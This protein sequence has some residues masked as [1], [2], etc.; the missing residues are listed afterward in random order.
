MNK[1]S[2]SVICFSL[3]VGLIL[4]V[5]ACGKPTYFNAI[6]SISCESEGF[7]ETEDFYCSDEEIEGEGRRRR[8]SKRNHHTHRRP[9]RSGSVNQTGISSADGE[10]LTVDKCTSQRI[11]YLEINKSYHHVEQK[12]HSFMIDYNNTW[13]AFDWVRYPSNRYKYT[14]YAVPTE[15]TPPSLTDNGVDY[16]SLSGKFG[17]MQSEFNSIL[18]AEHI[19]LN[20]KYLE[21]AHGHGKG[22]EMANTLKDI[23]RRHKDSIKSMRN[24]W[25]HLMVDWRSAQEQ[26]PR[27]PL[28]ATQQIIVNTDNLWEQS[29]G[30]AIKVCKKLSRGYRLTSRGEDLV[31]EYNRLWQEDSRLLEKYN[32][33]QN[34]QAAQE[35]LNNAQSIVALE[36][37]LIREIKS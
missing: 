22:T 32:R 29:Y 4:C 11:K 24:K 23:I 1:K 2:E 34:I 31:E 12:M 5:F 13:A 28:N 27:S 25:S 30:F 17:Q 9:T 26:Q 16:T 6:N 14:K 19:T 37:K 33:T 21:F 3:K 10:V 7:L 35:R 8:G 15:A 20:Q 36:E 18:N